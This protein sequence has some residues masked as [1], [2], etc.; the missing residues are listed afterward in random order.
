MNGQEG[1]KTIRLSTE[2]RH[3]LASVIGCVLLFCSAGTTAAEWFTA[4]SKDRP[5]TVEVSGL[6]VSSD[7][8]HISPPA[9][10]SWQTSITQLAGDGTHVK[11]GDLLVRFDNSFHDNR[12]REYQGQLDVKRRE[13]GSLNEK[14]TQEQE[15]ERLRLAELESQA[16]KAN[17]KAEQPGHLIP[18]VQYQKLIE[19][20]ILA[21]LLLE[22]EKK[23][24]AISARLRDADLKAAEASVERYRSRVEGL[25]A[26]QQRMTI[27]AP[28]D[29]LVTV[30]TDWQENKLDINSMVGPGIVVAYLHDDSSLSVEAQVPEHIGSKILVDQDCDIVAET[31]GGGT[32]KG[33]VSE[34][35]STVRKK[36]RFS[37]EIVRDVKIEFLDPPSS[38]SI[39]NGVQITIQIGVDKDVIAV[40]YEAL[41]YRAGEPGIVTS[42]GWRPVEL[43]AQ[44]EGK[45]IVQTGIEDGDQVRL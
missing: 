15:Q 12:L 11:K 20:K 32:F 33:R 26:E 24:L 36:N 16:K 4:E 30:G 2:A 3:Q 43:G 13:F 39:G 18:S 23:R 5:I 25:L 40:P 34:V 38:V 28:R 14:H 31:A 10:R 21:N 7:V 27:R 42:S 1:M 9:T 19:E 44:S 22:Q 41:V 37:N 29:G 17:R 8:V 35:G 6:V 45:V